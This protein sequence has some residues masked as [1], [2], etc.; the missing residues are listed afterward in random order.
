MTTATTFAPFSFKVG[1]RK[2]EY[3]DTKKK[4]RKKNWL[5]VH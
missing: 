4:E 2:T 5:R 1:L 3:F